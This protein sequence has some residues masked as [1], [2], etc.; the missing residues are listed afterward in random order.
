MPKIVTVENTGNPIDNYL[1]DGVTYSI[2]D[3]QCR[4]L[5][6]EVAQKLIEA[7]PQLKVIGESSCPESIKQEVKMVDEKELIEDNPLSA[8]EQFENDLRKDEKFFCSNCG[9]EFKNMHGL[10]IHLKVHE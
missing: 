5:V 4:D 8:K 7:F 10:R 1:I 2:S 9:R 3:N 6:E